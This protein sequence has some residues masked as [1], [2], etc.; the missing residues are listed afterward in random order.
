MYALAYL[1]D[2]GDKSSSPKQPF[3]ICPK[4]GRFVRI[5]GHCECDAIFFDIFIHN[6]NENLLNK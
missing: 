5:D 6:E 3:T 4:C 2:T 1:S